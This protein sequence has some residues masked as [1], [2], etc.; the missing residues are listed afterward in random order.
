MFLTEGYKKIK[1]YA[2]AVKYTEI[3][4]YLDNKITK[5]VFLRKEETLSEVYEF[6]RTRYKNSKLSL[7]ADKLE[8]YIY[9]LKY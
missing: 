6:G 1:L 9:K 4:D 3:L 7:I 2:W 8:R 5:K